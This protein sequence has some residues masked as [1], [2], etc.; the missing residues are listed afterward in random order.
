MRVAVGSSLVSFH[1]ERP[2]GWK[3]AGSCNIVA[4][5][6]FHTAGN[7]G[8]NALDDTQEL[9]Y[10]PIMKAIAAT[11]YDSCVGRELMPKSDAFAA[12]EAAY[13]V[14]DGELVPG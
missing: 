5:L 14:C 9:N 1:K 2:F 7:P 3:R 10:P 12:L 4:P 13:R 6:C 11:D 8:R